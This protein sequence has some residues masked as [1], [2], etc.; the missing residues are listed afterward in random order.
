MK[1]VDRW[2]DYRCDSCGKI[3]TRGAAHICAPEADYVAK[4][5]AWV[6]KNGPVPEHCPELG[7]CWVWRGPLESKRGYGRFYTGYKKAPRY[8]YAHHFS[9]NLHYGP[10]PKDGKQFL[11]KCDF[12]KCV[13]PDHLFRGTP[14]ENSQDMARK[15]RQW[16]QKAGPERRAESAAH[17]RTGCVSQKKEKT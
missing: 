12:R 6:D 14:K 9:W 2:Q 17:A 5:W 16:L 11:H 8:T 10:A 4:F 13:R 15:G 3:K 1:R 7:P